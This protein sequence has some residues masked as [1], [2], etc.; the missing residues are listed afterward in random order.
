MQNNNSKY[1]LLL[2]T[3]LDNICKKKSQHPHINRVN[4]S[5]NFEQDVGYLLLLHT[6][7]LLC[8]RVVGLIQC[9]SKKGS[10]LVSGISQFLRQL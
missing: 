7:T 1:Y 8:I 3:V 9:V 2:K 10:T 5:I 4:Y 6:T